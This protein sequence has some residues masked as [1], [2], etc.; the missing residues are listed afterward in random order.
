MQCV[1]F[2]TLL[3]TRARCSQLFDMDNTNSEPNPTVSSMSV[4]GLGSWLREAGI[5]EKFCDVLTGRL[6]IHS[7]SIL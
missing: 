4:E 5:P 3:A 7:R 2:F 6:S 1:F